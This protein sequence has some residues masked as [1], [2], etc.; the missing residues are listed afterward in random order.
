MGESSAGDDPSPA[1]TGIPQAQIDLSALRHNLAVARRHTPNSKQ[2]A[3]IKAD[4]Y[5]HGMLRV[6]QALE[7]ADAFAVARLVEA[8]ALR[9]AGITK[10]IVVLE[11]ITD[12]DE[13]E[14]AQALHLQ[15]VVHQH[16]QIHL[17]EQA[18][19]T[20]LAIWLKVDT[21]MHRLGFSTDEVRQAHQR[22]S[23]CRVVAQP[24]VL[25]THLANADDLNDSMT[26]SQCERF[27]QATEGLAGS[28]S[29]ANSAGILG[30]PKSH[31]EW[32]RP[33]IMLYGASPFINSR[34]SDYDLQPVMT[35]STTLL[36]IKSCRK[37]D[38]VGY[39][40]HWHCPEDMPVGIAAIGYGDGYP[41]HAPATTPVWVNGQ[42]VSLIGRVSMDMICLDLRTVTEARIGDPVRLWG[43][44]LPAEDVADKVGT[45]SYELFCRLTQRVRFIES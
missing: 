44:D 6:A 36:A 19:G 16:E 9:E 33:G 18:T 24:P 34:A 28:R 38:A 23:A 2:L 32:S 29:I 25:M 13:L 21:G 30:W 31:A 10:D 3:V 7:A 11:G 20:A 12:K 15:L 37:G 4:A 14:Q 45:I 42:R 5:G 39:G 8:R 43:S 40:G 22:L 27:H 1:I 35:L 26:H 41:R 17:L